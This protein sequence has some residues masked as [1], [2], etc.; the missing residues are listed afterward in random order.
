MELDLD[1]RRKFGFFGKSL[2]GI[3]YWIGAAAL[4]NLIVILLPPLG[5]VIFA[6]L[7]V[8]AGI[9]WLAWWDAGNKLISAQIEERHTARMLERERE[10]L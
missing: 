6:G 5:G 4:W 9:V 2:L 10:S 3:G 1:T 8:I 7:T